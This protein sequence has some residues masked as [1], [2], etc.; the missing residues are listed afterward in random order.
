MKF[1]RPTIS[2]VKLGFWLFLFTVWTNLG[3]VL[4]PAV[5][6]PRV[7]TCAITVWKSWAVFGLGLYLATFAT[8]LHRL[9]VGA[10]LALVSVVLALQS[11]ESG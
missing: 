10:F 1:S 9:R 5:V 7:N 4:R 2:N 6:A 8:H 11:S 3:G